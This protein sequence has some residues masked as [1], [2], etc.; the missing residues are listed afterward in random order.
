L[1]LTCE[2]VDDDFALRDE[3]SRDLDCGRIFEVERDAA[4]ALMY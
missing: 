3:P 1:A 4:L 2:I